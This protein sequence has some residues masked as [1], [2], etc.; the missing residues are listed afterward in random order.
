VLRRRGTFLIWT[1][2][3]VWDVS[4]EILFIAR[5]KTVADRCTTHCGR[6]SGAADG[7]F[8]VQI[9]CDRVSRHGGYGIRN[10]YRRSRFDAF[11]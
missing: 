1:A 11:Q 5:A 4:D 2:M 10:R 3:H 6:L 8:A 9:D 7:A